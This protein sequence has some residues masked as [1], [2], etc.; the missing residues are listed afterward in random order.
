M[1]VKILVTILVLFAA[2][3]S[4]ELLYHMRSIYHQ[5]NDPYSRISL[6]ADIRKKLFDYSV[7]IRE[8]DYDFIQPHLEIDDEAYLDEHYKLANFINSHEAITTGEAIS[9]KYWLNYSIANKEEAVLKFSQL[10]GYNNEIKTKGAIIDSKKINKHDKIDKLLL[11][12]RFGNEF[13]VY[14]GKPNTAPKGIVI[15]IHGINSGPDYIIGLNKGD[16]SRSFG[17]YWLSKGYL[18]YA[19]LVSWGDKSISLDRLNYSNHGYDVSKL[20]DLIHVIKREHSNNN[21]IVAAGISNGAVLSEMIGILSPD[22]DAVVSICGTQGGDLFDRY[23][24]GSN[25]VHADQ[26]RIYKGDLP[27]DYHFYYRRSGQRKLLAPKFLIISEGSHDHGELKFR[28]IFRTIDFYRENGISNR[29]ALNVFMGFHE[30]DP[31]GEYNEFVRL[32]NGISKENSFEK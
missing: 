25:M 12:G 24:A 28:S 7:V 31:E 15:A 5:I 19:P 16:Y 4:N 9:N 17:G 30:S 10:I 13:T 11:K 23:L 21:V 2:V 26:S 22:I 29:I 27:R 20:L 14:R 18:V 8:L 3:N 32:F 6:T 1:K